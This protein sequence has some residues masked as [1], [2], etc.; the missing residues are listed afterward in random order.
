M[1]LDAAAVTLLPDGQ[2]L[3]LRFPAPVPPTGCTVTAATLRLDPG[4]AVA[5]QPVE[6]LAATGDGPVTTAAPAPGTRAWTVTG[7]LTPAGLRLA[8][9]PAAVPAAT[10]TLRVEFG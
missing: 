10:P 4:P 8:V 3:D 6:V 5:G 1:V 9:R 7:L 2:G